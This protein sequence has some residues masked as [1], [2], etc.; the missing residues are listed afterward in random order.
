MTSEKPSPFTSPAVATDT[1]EVGMTSWLPSAVQ[2]A[3][4]E[5]RRRAV[6]DEGPPL[7][8]WPFRSRGADDDIG[9]AVAVHI[10]R[11]CHR[12]TEP[13]VRLVALRG[14]GGGDAES[15]PPSRGRRRPGPRR[16]GRCRKCAPTMTSEKPSPFTSPAVATET[17]NRASA[18]SA[19]RGPG[20]RGGEA[21]PP[22]PK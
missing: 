22:S 7:V 4:V 2:A 11:R 21:R 9:E 3:V 10:P 20:W 17:P 6:V 8:A 16:S 14:P 13:G 19:L 5:A 15:P 12:R 18:W 1:A